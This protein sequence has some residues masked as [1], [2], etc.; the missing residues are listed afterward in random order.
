LAEEQGKSR[1]VKPRGQGKRW[2]PGESGN[3]K[4]RTPNVKTIPEILRKIGEEQGTN[5]ALEEG[6]LT[7]LEVVMSQVYKFAKEGKPWAVQFMAERTE[8]KVTDTLKIIGD[9]PAMVLAEA[10]DEYRLEPETPKKKPAVRKA[11][12]NPG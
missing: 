9:S 12:K 6:G 7:K 1:E 5:V 11:K 10:L 4:G 8:G 2:K 3:P